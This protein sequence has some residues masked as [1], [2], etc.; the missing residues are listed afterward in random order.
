MKNQFVSLLA[1]EE[2]LALIEAKHQ[3]VFSVLGMHKHPTQNVLIVRSFYPDALSVEVI[4]SKTNKLVALLDL[5]DPAGLFEG[6]LGRRRNAFSYRLRVSYKEETLV[7]DDPYSYPSMIN[8]DDLY[9]FCEGTHE[10]TYQWMGAHQLEVDGVVGKVQGTHFVL[11]APDASR[12]SVVGDFNFWDGRLHVMR[13][14]P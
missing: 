9:L 3:D 7:V 13:K 14:H 1:K 2:I 8:N 4:D 12:V 6:K 11:W 10:K 5:V